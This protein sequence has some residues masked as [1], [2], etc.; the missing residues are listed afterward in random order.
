MMGEIALP[1]TESIGERIVTLP[2]FSIMSETQVDLVV[3][4][5]KIS[6]EEAA[7]VVEEV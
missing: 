1:V 3:G 5:V 7:L 2:L 6:I 4:A